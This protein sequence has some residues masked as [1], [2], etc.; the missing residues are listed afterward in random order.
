MTKYFFLFY[1]IHYLLKTFGL[2]KKHMCIEWLLLFEYYEKLIIST[3]LPCERIT[4]LTQA[5]LCCF[6]WT[7]TIIIFVYDYCIY[8]YNIR[9]SCLCL[10]FSEYLS[11]EDR[12]SV[13]V[14]F[15]VKKNQCMCL[16]SKVYKIIYEQQQRL[17]IKQNSF[18]L[19]VQTRKTNENGVM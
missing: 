19:L 2:L 12:N 6:L 18:S 17:D 9:P 3:D 11:V 8:P 5:W 15:K 7:E 10:S 13:H 4:S 16:M 1:K 14:I